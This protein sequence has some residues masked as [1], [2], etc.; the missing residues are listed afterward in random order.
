MGGGNQTALVLFPVVRPVVGPNGEK[1][2][3][4][5]GRQEERRP[6]QR[7]EVKTRNA[8]DIRRKQAAQEDPGRGHETQ[9]GEEIQPLAQH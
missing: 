6:R 2:A 9:P 5:V 4:I 7:I 8:D 1:D 3:N